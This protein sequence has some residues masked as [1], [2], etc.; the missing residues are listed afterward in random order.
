MNLLTRGKALL[1]RL[2]LKARGYR[3]EGEQEAHADQL[4]E[5]QI[6]LSLMASA[7]ADDADQARMA[8][9]IE[10][11]AENRLTVLLGRARLTLEEKRERDAIQAALAAR[12]QGF[13]QPVLEQ[14]TDGGARPQGFLGPL[15]ALPVMAILASPMTWVAVGVAAFGVQTA[16]LEN[17]KGDLR[18]AR[19]ETRAAVEERDA[20]KERSELYAAAVGDA[21]RLANETADALEAERSRAARAAAAE[22]RRQREVQ[23]VLVGSPEPPSWSLRDDEPVSPG[24]AGDH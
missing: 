9:D 14:R 8:S 10:H 5:T 21:R 12:R 18:D 22:R 19:T 24:P 15:A 1:S 2:W 4:R 7:P 23:N 17:A 11:G 3:Y 16:R 20:W 6:S 13:E